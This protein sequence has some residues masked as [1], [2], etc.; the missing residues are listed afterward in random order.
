[1]FDKEENRSDGYF[2]LLHV[3]GRTGA[4]RREENNGEKGQGYSRRTGQNDILGEG[5]KMIDT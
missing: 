5:C 1:L 4:G 3:L 2:R